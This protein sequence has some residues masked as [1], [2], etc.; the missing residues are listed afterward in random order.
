[1]TAASDL[2][3]DATPRVE[4]VGEVTDLSGNEVDI[5]KDTLRGQGVRQPVAY[6]DGNARR[7]IAGG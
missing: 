5:T 3:P 4:V 2:E 1:M 7:G 6:S